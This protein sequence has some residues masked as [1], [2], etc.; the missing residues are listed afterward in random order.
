MI[1][2]VLLKLVYFYQKFLSVMAVGSCRHYPSC[3]EYA[4]QQF[5]LNP[6]WLAFGTSLFRIARCNQMFAGG[7]EYVRLS[8]FKERPENLTIDSIK[9]WIIPDTGGNYNVVKNFSF[10]G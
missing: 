5:E 8:R 7:F 3:S 9:Y 10:K 1:R 2:A 6:L 4:K